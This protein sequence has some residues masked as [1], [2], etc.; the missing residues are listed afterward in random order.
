MAAATKQEEKEMATNDMNRRDFLKTSGGVA[1]GV[2]VAS[3]GAGA[4]AFSVDAWAKELQTLNEHEAKT[5]LQMSRQIY[6]H[7]WLGDVYYAVVVNDLDAEA[8]GDS[9]A[10]GVIK[11][12]VAELDSAH[13]VAWVELSSGYQLEAL[14]A[15]ETSPLFQKVKGKA[16]VSLYNNPLVWREFGYEGPSAH[17]GGYID[18]GFDDLGWLDSPPESAS[19]KVG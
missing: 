18:R 10:R 5:L 12:G 1:T 13:G 9:E 6:P 3:A 8:S 17:L 4:L 15:M 2:A 14:K 16:L 7:P 19:P 11:D